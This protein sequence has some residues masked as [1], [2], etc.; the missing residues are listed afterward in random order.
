MQE[1]RAQG[2]QEGRAQG[3]QEGQRAMLRRMARARFG[4]LPEALERR[5]A[6]AD[7]ATLDLFADRL[8]AVSSP[9]ELA[10]DP[11]G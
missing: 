8:G 4:S 2:M 9:D 5:I 7:Q 11:E 6:E 10:V 1:G 3:M